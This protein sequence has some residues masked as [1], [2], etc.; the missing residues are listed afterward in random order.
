MKLRV[1]A[2]CLAGVLLAAAESVSAG[3]GR[4]RQVAIPGKTFAPAVL[5]V[6]V[7]DTVTWQ[8]GD[9]TNHT[10]TADDGAFDSGFLS[11]G[12]TFSLVFP[13]TGRFDYHCTI[14]RYMRGTI[15]V[16]TL[17]LAAPAEPTTVGAAAMLT[18]LAPA[19]TGEVTLERQAPGADFAPAATAAPDAG[20]HFHF[21]VAADGPTVVNLEREKRKDGPTGDHH[22]LRLEIPR[23]GQRPRLGIDPRSFPLHQGF[24]HEVQIV[25][26]AWHDDHHIVRHSRSSR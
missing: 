6:L 18:G 19:G 8:N 24:H 22:E 21:E 2:A 14:H 15:E 13:R 11:P 10:V 1:V 16:D 9:V 3:D 5:Q 20:G 23:L 25:S 4:A 7:G 26:G 12:T 17:A